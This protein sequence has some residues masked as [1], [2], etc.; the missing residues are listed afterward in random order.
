MY[1]VTVDWPV[2]STIHA[3]ETFIVHNTVHLLSA[4]KA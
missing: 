3:L 4:N 1:N 2:T